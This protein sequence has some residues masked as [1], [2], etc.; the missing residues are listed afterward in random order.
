MEEETDYFLQ[1]I[2]KEKKAQLWT[3]NLNKK[4][5]IILVNL[6]RG[7]FKVIRLMCFTPFNEKFCKSQ[8]Y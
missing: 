1:I 5:K 7:D 2:N 6:G 3:G 4:K 8:L